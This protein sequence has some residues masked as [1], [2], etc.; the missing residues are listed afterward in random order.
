MISISTKNGSVIVK[1][2]KAAESCSCCGGSDCCR[3][4]Y[5]FATCTPFTGASSGCTAAN[6]SKISSCTALTSTISVSGFGQAIADAGQC[7]IDG[8]LFV[9]PTA[10]NELFH[11]RSL[12]FANGTYTCSEGCGDGLV[13]QYFRDMYFDG[14]NVGTNLAVSYGF[15]PYRRDRTP[16]PSGYVA[17][18]VKIEIQRDYPISFTSYIMFFSGTYE[19]DCI[20][21]DSLPASGLLTAG[22]T[23]VSVTC[24]GTVR[25]SGQNPCIL[26]PQ[27]ITVSFQD[28]PLP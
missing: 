4:Y 18:R 17:F 21:I 25:P 24:N 7:D 27:V 10:T 8:G 20:S 19:S 3:F 28:N 14:L 9:S 12:A 22:R 11:D 2:G 5:D 26:Q 23:P 1:D 15:S 16:C 13:L 6:N